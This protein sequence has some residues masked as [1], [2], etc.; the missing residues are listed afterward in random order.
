LTNL[1]TCAPLKQPVCESEN[2]AYWFRKSLK[3]GIISLF[4]D[5][6][7]HFWAMITVLNREKST[8]EGLWPVGLAGICSSG[9]TWD[10]LV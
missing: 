9:N 3:R 10:K 1:F 4:L 5:A 7:R 2:P 6:I 8:R